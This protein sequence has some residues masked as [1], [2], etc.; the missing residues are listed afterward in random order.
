MGPLLGIFAAGAP[1]LPRDELRRRA[2]ALV[3]EEES[4]ADALAFW[5]D[6]GSLIHYRD[7][8]QLAEQVFVNTNWIMALVNGLVEQAHKQTVFSD[9]ADR[10]L[11]DGVLSHALC[12]E[13]WRG[14]AP[15][16]AP[17]GIQP[18][19]PESGTGWAP[20]RPEQMIARRAQQQRRAPLPMSR[21]RWARAIRLLF[22]ASSRAAQ[23]QHCG[24][25]NVYD[26]ANG[27]GAC[28]GL[29]A[30]GWRCDGDFGPGQAYYG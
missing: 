15:A 3:K 24:T 18:R 2:A 30:T 21:R 1:H 6:G 8:P 20:A 9:A 28:A 12:A 19:G 17:S 13:L 27:A 10:L 16:V 4:F 29:L 5:H 11:M 23:A 26:D 7:V 14:V 25:T 22:F